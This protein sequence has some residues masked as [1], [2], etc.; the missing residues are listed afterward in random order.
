MKTGYKFLPIFLAAVLFFGN[1]SSTVTSLADTREV[2]DLATE[3]ETVILEEVNTAD[4]GA[5]GT[6]T[7]NES[8]GDASRKSS[9][10]SENESPSNALGITTYSVN[11][12]PA[13]VDGVITL[14]R[15]ENLGNVTVSVKEDTVLDLNGFTL[16]SDAL[17][18]IEV[19]NCAELTICDNGDS[20]AGKIVNT[21]STGSSNTGAVRLEPGSTMTMNS[22]ILSGE[23]THGYGIYATTSMIEISGGSIYGSRQ[24]IHAQNGSDLIFSG[25]TVTGGDPT[26]NAE[27]L[28]GIAVTVNSTGTFTGGTVEAKYSEASAVRVGQS[29]VTIS[30]GDFYGGKYGIDVENESE[31]TIEEDAEIT[32]DVAGLGIYYGCEVTINGGSISGGNDADDEDPNGEMAAIDIYGETASNATKLNINGGE[33]TGS[34]GISSTADSNNIE[35]NINGG[36]FITSHSGIYMPNNGTLNMYG[37][38]IDAGANGITVR[39]GTVN[40]TGGVIQASGIVYGESSENALKGMGILV[41][42]GKGNREIILDISGGEI[43]GTTYALYEQDY[44]NNHAYEN[45]IHITVS[46]GIFTNNYSEDIHPVDIRDEDEGYDGAEKMIKIT[47]GYFSDHVEESEYID[48][49]YMCIDGVTVIGESGEE[50]SGYHAVIPDKIDESNATLTLSQTS[51]TYNGRAQVPSLTVMFNNGTELIEGKHFTASY[52]RGANEIAAESVIG[53]GTYTVTVT[54]TGSDAMCYFDAA[55][56]EHTK[57]DELTGALSGDFRIASSYSGSS[58]SGSSSSSS[59]GTY[60]DDSGKTGQWHLDGSLFTRSDGYIPSYEYLDI[61][62]QIWYFY[63]NGYAVNRKYTQYYAEEAIAAAGNIPE[64]AGTWKLCGW[65][66]E[67]DDGTYP[68][69]EWDHLWYNDRADWYFFDEDGWMIDGWLDWD[70]NTYYLHTVSDGTRGHMYTGWH[71]IDGVWYYFSEDNATLG[72][73]LKDTVTPDG[74]RVDAEGRYIP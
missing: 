72:A 23:G 65:W 28:Y 1:I 22:G 49:G 12:L 55:K 32:G 11:S 64:A 30:G 14:E 41:A 10:S 44:S 40:I 71:E 63:K 38:I 27:N 7:V 17:F 57:L 36:T 24:G 5:E 50:Y 3:E 54:G 6:Y 2:A 9:G 4:D 70:G 29:E 15:N 8:S 67:Y 25:G 21:H 56:G 48:E 19:S 69:N 59:S 53:V 68:H 47:G 60:T 35:I 61:D 74:Y 31:V 20:D 52:S 42:Q 43:F 33:F 18:T 66:F 34:E 39:S 73:L 62:G 26:S 58:S 51:F 45:D 46:G 16:T 37:G 13:A